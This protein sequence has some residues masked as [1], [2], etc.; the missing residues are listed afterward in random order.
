MIKQILRTYRQFNDL[1]ESEKTACIEKHRYSFD[2]LTNILLSEQL[3]NEILPILHDNGFLIDT[4]DIEY[5][6]NYCQGR[7]ACFYTKNQPNLQYDLL[8]DGL[9]IPHKKWLFD[10]I[11]NYCEVEL[12]KIDT[13]Y[14]HENTVRFNL[15]FYDRGNTHSRIEKMLEKMS[16]YAEKKR[17]DLSCEICE[18]MTENWENYMSDDFIKNELIEN[19]YYFDDDLNIVDI[20]S[21]ENEGAK[22]E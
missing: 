11:D 18:K 9:E 5:D 10:I 22:N 6:L 20:D 8:F 17:Y 3:E 16:D 12:K 13:Y 7:G 4:R 14:S 1:T 19:E 21:I 15:Y 2:D